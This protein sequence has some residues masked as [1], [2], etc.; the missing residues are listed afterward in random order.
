MKALP[1]G[2]IRYSAPE[3]QHDDAV[4]A[5]GLAIHGA[6]T[7]GGLWISSGPPSAAQQRGIH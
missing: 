1:T 4:M 7:S 6:M 2:N 3:G 5:L